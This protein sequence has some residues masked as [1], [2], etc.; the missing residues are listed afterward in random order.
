VRARRAG[1]VIALVSRVEPGSSPAPG[2]RVLRAVSA[3]SSACLVLGACASLLDIPEDPRLSPA[4]SAP[5]LA[6]PPGEV[7]VP[8]DAPPA[9]PGASSPNPDSEVDGAGATISAEQTRPSM[10]AAAATQGQ[11]QAGSGADPDA[12]IVAPPEPQLPEEQPEPPVGSG[13]S[14]GQDPLPEPSPCGQGRSL[15][16]NG[17]CFALISTP[18]SWADAR[19]SCEE[20]GGG[21]ELAVPRDAALNAFLS[22]LIVDEAWLGGTD[23]NVEGVWRWIDDGDIFWQGDETGAAPDGAFA[24]WNPTEPNGGGN[25]DCLRLVARVGNEWAD[26]ECELLRSALCEGPGP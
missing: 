4:A 11:A 14:T 1:S 16:P 7:A 8:S 21:W 24:A 2:A 22:T 20:L 10:P 15:G 26:L 23:Q 13:G 17:R 6:P 3:A 25:S 9:A 18:L 5:A 19:D 12:G